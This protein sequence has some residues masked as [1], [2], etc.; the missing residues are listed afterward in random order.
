MTAMPTTTRAG[1]DDVRQWSQELARDPSSEAFLPLAETLRVQGQL[2]RACQVATRGV[3]SHP[4]NP[5]ARDLL[6]RILVDRGELVAAFEEWSIVLQLAPSHVGAIKGMAFV[7]FQQGMLAEAERLLVLANTQAVSP[8]LGITA[9]IDTIR[10]TP[11]ESGGITFRS[12][13]SDI[14]SAVALHVDPRKVKVAEAVTFWGGQGY[15]T[16][17]LE[18]LLEHQ[19]S[20]LDHEKALRGYAAT[21][22]RLRELEGRVIASDSALGRNDVFRDPER[23]AEAEALATRVIARGASATHR[24]ADEFFLDHEKVVWHWPD[25]GARLTEDVR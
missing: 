19:S 10:A 6:A 13:V 16:A 18:C 22:E 15:K 21:V 8:D 1:S 12:F 25:L 24:A 2:D 5:K 7:R 23:L 14:A 17:A 20:E 9:A 4:H 3:A 11:R